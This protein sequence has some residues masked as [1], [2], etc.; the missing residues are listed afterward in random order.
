MR[1]QSRGQSYKS[2]N[3]IKH[4]W[5]IQ[6]VYFVNSIKFIADMMK[7]ESTYGKYFII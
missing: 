4:F 7:I 6:Q 2:E 5:S 1:N 3:V